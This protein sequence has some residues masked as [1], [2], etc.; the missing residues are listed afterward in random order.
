M[1][2]GLE[3]AVVWLSAVRNA[4]KKTRIDSRFFSRAGLEAHERIT[5]SPHALL[6]DITSVFRK[7][8]FDIKADTYVSADE[9]GG[10]PFVRVGDLHDV[11]LSSQGLARIS[12]AANEVEA[13]TALR[14]GDLVL[15]KTAYPAAS[16]VTLDAVNVSQD[17]IAVKLSRDGA[18]RFNTAYL[19]AYLNSRIGKQLAG[20][21]FQ[22]NVQEHFG[23]ED[24]ASLPIPEFS[25]KLQKSVS[26]V[27]ALAESAR[28][29]AV[30][31]QREAEEALL[32]KLG[33]EGWSPPEPLTYT[34]SAA[35][36][37]A[38]G[39]LDAQYYMPAKFAVLDRLGALPGQPLAQL[40]NSVRDMFDPSSGPGD[41]LVRNY[42][43]TDALQLLLDDSVRPETLDT[44]ESQKKSMSCDAVTS[45][46][47]LARRSSSYC[48]QNPTPVTSA[49]RL[50][51][52][53]C[54][55]H[56]CRSCSNGVRT[57]RSIP[58]SAS[59]TC[60]QSLSR[61]SCGQ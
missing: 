28:D 32:G 9:E 56:R 61:I 35:R 60:L 30:A 40:V 4:N 44:I 25:R 13:K 2:E 6:G 7:G 41:A 31:A 5:A 8:I 10:V 47:S 22:G 12:A 46:Q 18:S 27:V 17:T 34:R 24:A 1:T 52:F 14:R 50:C 43:L 49:P 37:R 33:F 23:L 55:R 26:E 11:L 53:T 20:R 16:L 36:V 45:C 39:R 29:A 51:S 59:M 42:D 54:D 38:A 19:A 58:D 15:S 48:A 21:L 3:V 57:A